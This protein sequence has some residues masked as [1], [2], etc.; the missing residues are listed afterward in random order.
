[1]T[2]ATLL[3]PLI[4]FTFVVFSTLRAHAEKFLVVHY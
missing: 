2:L 3:P 4:N 1:M